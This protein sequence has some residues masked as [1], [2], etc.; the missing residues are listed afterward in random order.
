MPAS[1]AEPGHIWITKHPEL[2]KE[3][4]YIAIHILPYWEGIAAQPP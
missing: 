4:D 1:T 2:A 3:V